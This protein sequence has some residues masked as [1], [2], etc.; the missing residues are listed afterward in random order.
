MGMFF[1]KDEKAILCD[2]KINP[3]ISSTETVSA[4]LL[5][6]MINPLDYVYNTWN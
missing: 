5:F 6:D 4:S 2:L 1:G 3:K